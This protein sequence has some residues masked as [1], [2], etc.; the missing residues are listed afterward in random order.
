MKYIN[1]CD[2]FE[3]L[4][5]KAIKLNPTSGVSVSFVSFARYLFRSRESP[6]ISKPVKEINSFGKCSEF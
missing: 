3:V 6:R 4:F 2:I 5:S 1:T